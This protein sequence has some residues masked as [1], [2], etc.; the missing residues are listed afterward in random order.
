MRHM[1]K[2]DGIISTE[3]HHCAIM[4]IITRDKA[5]IEEGVGTLYKQPVQY[6]LN[7]CDNDKEKMKEKTMREMH[8]THHLKDLRLIYQ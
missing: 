1:N 5:G 8:S 6:T 7:T 4:I 3:N 2:Y